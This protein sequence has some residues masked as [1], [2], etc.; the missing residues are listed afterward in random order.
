LGP[1]PNVIQAIRPHEPSSVA[2]APCLPDGPPA[3]VV[4]IQ[5][6]RADVQEPFQW[7]LEAIAL[8]PG[9]VT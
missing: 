4:Q 2:L 7:T 8:R 5:T 6:M 1:Q 3:G 9:G